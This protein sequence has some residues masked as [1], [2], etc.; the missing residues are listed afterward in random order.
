MC[1][2]KAYK[3]N[4]SKLNVPGFRKTKHLVNMEK[5]Y[6]SDVFYDDAKRF[7]SDCSE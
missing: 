5:D 2:S 7:V 3:K 6:G 4:I 1:I